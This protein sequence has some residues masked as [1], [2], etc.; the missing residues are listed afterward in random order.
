MEDLNRGI[1]LLME[2]TKMSL[3]LKLH[4]DYLCKALATVDC[5]MFTVPKKQ[6]ATYFGEEF[7]FDEKEHL[8]MSYGVPFVLKEGMIFSAPFVVP[9]FPAFVGC[10][11]KPAWPRVI[12]ITEDG[13]IGPATPCV[14]AEMPSIST[15]GLV[16]GRRYRLNGY[17]PL[18]AGTAI[19]FGN[20]I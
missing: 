13:V 4:R 11:S 12:W 18:F 15:T 5:H 9:N 2:T 14:V 17:A 1:K 8:T 16:V 6:M 19:Y 3:D 20:K 10:Y 7:Q